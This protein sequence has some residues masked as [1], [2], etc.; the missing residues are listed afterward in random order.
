MLN[1]EYFL[2]FMSYDNTVIDPKCYR[3]TETEILF[4]DSAKAKKVLGWSPTISFEVLVEEMVKAD[5]DF[6]KARG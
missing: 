3:K 6:F 2:I 5:Y 4:G 1:A